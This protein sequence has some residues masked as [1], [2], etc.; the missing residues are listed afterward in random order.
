MRRL[1]SYFALGLATAVIGW[2]PA[3]SNAAPAHPAAADI[4]ASTAAERKDVVTVHRR[5]HHHRHWRG[6]R[7]YYYG[8]PYRHYGHRYNSHRGNYWGH[9]RHYGHYGRKGC[10]IGHWGL[11]CR[12]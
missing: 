4:R 5:N 12:F 7:Q 11:N 1:S 2:M 8:A 3:A 9:R 6:H 10:S